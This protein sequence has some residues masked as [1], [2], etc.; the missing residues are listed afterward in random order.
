MLADNYE[1]ASLTVQLKRCGRLVDHAIDRMLKRH[2]IARSQYRV[3][4]HVARQKELTQKELTEILEVQGSTLTLIVD[5]LV[6]KAWLVR[7]AS[8][9][10]KRVKTLRLTAAGKK[11]F[12]RIPD[13]ADEIN[14]I[15]L[16][17]MTE[18]EAQNLEAALRKIIATLQKTGE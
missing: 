14:R 18:R 7:E 8:E 5:A 6:Q 16:Q 4:Y 1:P 9:Q 15:V 13:P 10:D 2:G 3:L 11:V 12:S 17:M